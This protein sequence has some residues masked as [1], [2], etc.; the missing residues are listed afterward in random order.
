MMDAEMYGMM[1]R[2]KIE[3]CSSAP[4]A[5]MSYM[6]K[7]VFPALAKKF[8]SAVRSTPGFGMKIPIR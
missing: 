1:P 3:N 2:V 5:N 4:P 6:P 8:W 7:R